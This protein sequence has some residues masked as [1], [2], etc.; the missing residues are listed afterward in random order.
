M[1]RANIGDLSFELN[2]LTKHAAIVGTTGS[3]KTV[4]AK[5]LVEEAIAKGI[6]VI[7]I[8]PKGDIGGLGIHDKNF[9]FRPFLAQK[10]AEKTAQEYAQKVDK[11]LNLTKTQTTI[12]TPKAKT[13]KQISLLPDLSAPKEVE[14]ELADAAADSVLSLANVK[15]NKDKA[16]ALLSTIILHF[17][18]QKKDVTIESLIK[19]VQLPPIETVGS[20][21]LESFMNEKERNKLVA[22]LNIILT[23]PAKKAWGEGQPLSMKD[24]LK[25]NNL[26]IIDLRSIHNVEDKRFAV[27]QILMQLYKFLLTKGGTQRLRF[28]LYIDELAGILPPPPAN[29]PVKKLLELLIRQARAFG[30][31]IVL[32]T[33]SPG[34]IDYKLLGNLGTRFIGKL[35]TNNDIK[36]VAES[37]AIPLSDLR[38]Q[39]SNL[40]ITEF[41]LNDAVTN[42]TR[43]LKTRWLNTLHTGP[44]KP[45]EIEWINQPETRPKRDKTIKITK[46][47]LTKKPTK[48]AKK[49]SAK[50][51]N[52]VTTKHLLK[53]AQTT[54]K[55]AKR[56]KKVLSPEQSLKAVTKMLKKHA[57]TLQLK[58]AATTQ[59]ELTPHLK[60]VIEAKPYKKNRLPLQGPWIFDLTSKSIPTD[61]YLANTTFRTMIPQD[62]TIESPTRSVMQAI[63][64][65]QQEAKRDLK[66]TFYESTIINVVS[67]DEDEVVQ[68]N[69]NHLRELAQRRNRRLEQ[70]EARKKQQLQETIKNNNAKKRANTTRLTTLKAKRM[71]RRAVSGQNLK[72]KTA[73]MQG[74]E[75][76]NKQLIRENEK[77]KKKL[78]ELKENYRRKR[79]TVLDQA[80]H[81]AHTTTK[82]KVYKPTNKDLVVHATI[83]LLPK[84]QSRR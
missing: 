14:G 26:S 59:K 48:Q 23:S 82:K 51:A 18:E 20:L 15:T 52:L 62:I 68:K 55:P 80:Y 70:E 10:K 65:A 5:V 66:T 34:D 13:G 9:D 2:K 67:D 27:E 58:T 44:L 38:F 8:D 56:T 77:H 78:K 84:K 24:L 21:D 81:K 47:Q 33:Q 45:Q 42:S 46:Q 1:A 25:K 64:Y 4:M 43:K 19:H 37:S 79:E 7:A 57:G 76:R 75:K 60:L 72:T 61:N 39:L 31:G 6:P 54:K 16:Q 69:H 29:P 74:L 83:L 50:Q 12:F 35:R 11:P 36:K 73:E 63:R 3:G 40:Q 28:I 17:W 49:S 30:L 22:N 32:A 41:I 53:Q 71:I